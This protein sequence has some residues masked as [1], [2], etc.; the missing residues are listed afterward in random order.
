M[1][2]FEANQYTIEA[3]IDV[4]KANVDYET[5][6]WLFNISAFR[7]DPAETDKDET[8]KQFF[9]TLYMS[10]TQE[11]KSMLQKSYTGLTISSFFT[12]WT[13]NQ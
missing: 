1:Y 5:S 2:D 3:Q 8:R 13:Y 12:N 10:A 9:Y 4:S 6:F 11:F 7:Y